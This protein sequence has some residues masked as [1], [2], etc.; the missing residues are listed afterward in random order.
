MARLIPCGAISEDKAIA[1]AAVLG[2]EKI[3]ELSYEMCR[4]SHTLWCNCQ[5]QSLHGGAMLPQTIHPDRL[6][7]SQFTPGELLP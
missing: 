7:C 5:V 3:I 1:A 4:N 6:D 2:N